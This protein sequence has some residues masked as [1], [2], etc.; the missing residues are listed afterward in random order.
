M[1]KKRALAAFLW[2]AVAWVGYEIVWSMTGV[3]RIAGP[4]LAFAV[5]ALVTVDPMARFWPPRVVPPPLTG[6]TARSLPADHPGRGKRR[7]I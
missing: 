6:S 3:P 2:M 7:P 5:A 1:P 4:V